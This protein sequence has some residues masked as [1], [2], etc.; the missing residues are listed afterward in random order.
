MQKWTSEPYVWYE[1]DYL[2][3]AIFVLFN[4]VFKFTCEIGIQL[5]TSICLFFPIFFRY[6][7]WLVIFFVWFE[8]GVLKCSTDFSQNESEFVSQ[9]NILLV[10]VFWWI[11]VGCLWYM[12]GSL[13]VSSFLIQQ[14]VCFILRFPTHTYIYYFLFF[15]IAPRTLGFY[16]FFSRWFL[17]DVN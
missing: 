6:F 9:I 7:W 13:S 16:Q 4:G 2:L 5:N 12:F 8:R 15:L 3:Y 10:N 17:F 11:F 14:T 1:F